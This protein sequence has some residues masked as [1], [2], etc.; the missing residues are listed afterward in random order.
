MAGDTRTRMIEGTARLLATRGLQGASFG[1]IIEYTGVPRGSIYH[2]FPGGKDE[3][4]AEAI[5]YAG[6]HAIAQLRALDGAPADAIAERF[7][8]LWRLLLEHSNFHAG[9]SVLAVTI[10]TDV[11]ALLNASAT[12]FIRWQE[13]LSH[14]LVHGG[15]NGEDA[16][17]IAGLLVAA[18]EGAVV[19]SRAQR[20][21]APL[22]LVTDTILR[23]IRSL[24][25]EP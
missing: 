11:D 13:V 18:S 21:T 15:L 22:D 10:A 19:M 1:E 4:V 3:L 5:A 23:Q 12:I 2:H 16:E 25:A 24:L 7:L 17:R 6:E 20:S 8:S 9:C 14:L